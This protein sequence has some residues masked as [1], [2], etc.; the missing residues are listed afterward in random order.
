M[1]PDFNKIFLLQFSVV[2]GYSSSRPT[3]FSTTFTAPGTSKW[4]NLMSETPSNARRNAEARKYDDWVQEFCG[5]DPRACEN[6]QSP[7]K[8]EAAH[9]SFTP[10]LPHDGPS[11][12]QSSPGQFERDR[13]GERQ[14]REQEQQ[15]RELLGEEDGR[16]HSPEAEP[17]VEP[18]AP[19]SPIPPVVP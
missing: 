7:G 11:V 13:E 8:R 2:R 9:P 12:S 3:E 5:I 10:P 16:H 1:R 17:A 4:R 19:V 18:F 14:Q 6:G 15:N